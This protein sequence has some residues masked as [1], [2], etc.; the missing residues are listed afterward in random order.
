MI[1]H[2]KRIKQ[3]LDF[4][5]VGNSKIHPT[6]IDAVLE[7]DNKFL[8][9]FE[10]KLKGVSNSIGQEL[11]LKRLADCWEKT[12]G[13]AFVLYCEHETDPQEIVS[14]ENTTVHRI[15]SGGV[16]YK[17]NQNLKECLHKLADHYKITKLKKS[18]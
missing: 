7:F 1:K 2:E 13:N 12:N 17:R 8:I 4:R 5:G 15:Y 11:V 18:L 16:N 9:L 6:D 3:V 14:M 10:I